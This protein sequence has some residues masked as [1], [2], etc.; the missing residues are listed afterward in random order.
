MN[1]VI[2][3]N[4]SSLRQYIN[5]IISCKKVLYDFENTASPY[6]FAK[7]FNFT[8]PPGK[9]AIAQMQPF[10]KDSNFGFWTTD[11]YS[12]SAV[13]LFSSVSIMGDTFL[14]VDTNTLIKMD[15][16]EE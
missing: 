11:L 13:P 12:C 7:M 16:S 4:E 2:K 10:T 3:S 8:A 6:A 5:E 14:A 1:I 9:I 15:M